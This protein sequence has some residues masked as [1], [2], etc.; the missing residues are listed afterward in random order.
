MKFEK[1]KSNEEISN[2]VRS[3]K[4]GREIA[5]TG[6]GDNLVERLHIVPRIC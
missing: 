5:T 2:L 4:L 1:V 3:T 6:I